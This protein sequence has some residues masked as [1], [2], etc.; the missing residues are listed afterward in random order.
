GNKEPDCAPRVCRWASPAPCRLRRL[1]LV[2]ELQQLRAGL[3]QQQSVAQPCPPP[4]DTPPLH[5]IKVPEPKK[6]D[7]TRKAAVVNEFVDAVELYVTLRNPSVPAASQVLAVGLLFSGVARDW[8]R[9]QSK[10][11]PFKDM[12]H[13]LTRLHQHFP[14]HNHQRLLRDELA[15][16]VQR[17][18]VPEYASRFHN[19]LLQLEGVS[20]EEALDRFICGLNAS[21]RAQV[22]VRDPLTLDDAPPPQGLTP[23]ELDQI[24]VISNPV[25]ATP[26]TAAATSATATIE[27]LV[28]AV[29]HL[30]LGGNTARRPVQ[31]VARQP[32]SASSTPT[33]LT[34]ARKIGV[35]TTPLASTV[36]NHWLV[37]RRH[38]AHPAPT[39]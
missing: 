32:R 19:P 5:G 18:T 31:P 37:T 28:Q 30:R 27:A 2:R 8:L 9:L 38:R 34:P 21:T 29:D 26:A 33:K 25:H 13:L 16:C 17:T 15:C 11:A 12:E 36:Y 10:Q 20:P 3:Q 6:H 39:A 22:L 24:S 14:S 1:P 7:G 23:M 35:W 4:S